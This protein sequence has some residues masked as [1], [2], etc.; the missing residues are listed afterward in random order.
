[1][2]GSKQSHKEG[3]IKRLF[4]KPQKEKKKDSAVIKDIVLSGNDNRALTRAPEIEIKPPERKRAHI[5]TVKKKEEKLVIKPKESGLERSLKF[6]EK[7][8]D[9]F[10]EEV[11]KNKEKIQELFSLQKR[12][13]MLE[14]R[15]YEIESKRFGEMDKELKKLKEM[16]D[17]T[18]KRERE[19]N[20]KMAAELNLIKEDIKA[21]KSLEENIK[22]IGLKEIRREVE[23]L[24]EKA[25]W[26]EEN[27]EKFDIQPLYKLIKDIENKVDLLKI[28]S[29]MILE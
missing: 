2:M 9:K 11:L 17:E 24:K 18:T 27:I 23:I 29:P 20:D 8:V 16:I 3:I 13:S 4:F 6:I 1:M 21:L 22:N 26:M 25:K 14:N 10:A 28:S 15:I 7:E 12:L 5:E 19:V